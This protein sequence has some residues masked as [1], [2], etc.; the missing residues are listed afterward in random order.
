MITHR[1]SLDQYAAAIE[2]F[3][4]GGGLKIQIGDSV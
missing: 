1:F 4:Q 2:T 3:R